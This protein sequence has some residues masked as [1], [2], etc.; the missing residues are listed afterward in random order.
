MESINLYKL[1]HDIQCVVLDNDIIQNILDCYVKSN[2]KMIKTIKK[3]VNV[4]KTNKIQAK[5]DLNENKLIMIM[6]KLSNDNINE[7][8]A[9]YINNINLEDQIEKYNVILT[10]I[11][12]KMIKDI[13]FI[14]NYVNFAI[15]I[16]AIEYERLNVY[17]TTFIDLLKDTLNESS[18]ET[19]RNACYDIIKQL[20]KSGFFN[21]NIL[22]FMSKNLFLYKINYIDIYN[23]FSSFPKEYI[24]KYK[25][26]ITNVLSQISDN[27]EKILIS[28]LLEETTNNDN[29]DVLDEEDNDE[30]K[31]LI[32]N[33]LE[34]YNF[35]KSVDEV[36]E[37]IKTDCNDINKKNIFCRE[38]IEFNINNVSTIDMTLIDTLIKNKILFKSNISKG[39][40]L[41]LSPFVGNNHI[42][43]SDEKYDKII[44]ILKYLKNSNITKNIEHIF[45]KFRVKLF[46]DN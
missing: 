25:N 11:F 31:T 16:F 28:S 43:K 27:R 41:Y 39:L 24:Y 15:K 35:I 18:E 40:V 36:E 10:E 29:I 6:N 26:D 38:F 12:N 13:K 23:W 34:E 4:M 2:I 37:F 46:Y 33:I 17:P 45:K 5:K 44:D 19:I 30:F 7:L 3:Q 21:E 1:K 14:E 22:L 42:N 8:V 20:Q 9:E 32:T